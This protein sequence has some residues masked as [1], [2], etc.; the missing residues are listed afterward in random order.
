MLEGHLCLV[1]EVKANLM[2]LADFVSHLKVY[3]LSNPLLWVFCALSFV[4]SLSFVKLAIVVCKRWGWY[5]V[6]SE[7]KVHKGLVPR[8]GGAGFVS[9]FII[10]CVLYALFVR[11]TARTFA[12]FVVAGLL[13]FAS[14]VAD[15]FLDLR[16][17]VKFALQCIAAL[18]MVSSGYV[19]ESCFSLH[20]PRVLAAVGTFM[21]IVGIINSYNMIDGIDGLCGGLSALALF[22]LGLIYTLSQGN[23]AAMCF[24]LVSAILGF[25]VFNKPKAKIFMGDGGSQFLG[26]MVASVPLF[27]TTANFEGKKVL[28]AL[29]LVAIPMMDCIVAFVRRAREHR[30]VMSPDKLHLHHK[31][32]NLGLS[33]TGVLALLLSMQ[34][35]ICV[36]VIASMAIKSARAYVLLIALEAVMIGF[37]ATVHI[38]NKSKLKETAGERDN[39]SGR[40]GDK[41]LPRDE[42]GF[43]A[44]SASV[45]QADDILPLERSHARKNPRRPRDFHPAR[46]ASLF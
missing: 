15:D 35:V 14:G 12:P 29:C 32:M 11:G 24:L 34:T 41:A 4:L 23:S 5:D 37:F 20:V 6:P 26:F 27:T 43:K 36:C 31:L 9:A 16:A 38:L 3:A 45:R 7:R 39:P 17:V 19:F 13:V 2:S 42:G 8:L 25:L 28:I 21:W 44:T 1:N 22:T 33:S 30:S 46:L 18:I 10:A 40:L